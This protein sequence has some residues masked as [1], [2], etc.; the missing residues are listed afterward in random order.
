MKKKYKI[1]VIIAAAFI[2]LNFLLCMFSYVKFRTPNYIGS[3]VGVIKIISGE[4]FAEISKNP[5]IVLTKPN[6]IKIE[7]YLNNNGYEIIE[8]E[9]MGSMYSLRK[10]GEKQHALTS[11]DKYFSKIIWQ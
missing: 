5:K 9:R 6:N 10:D 8:E 1:T 7:E 4:D 11:V 2:V 3:F